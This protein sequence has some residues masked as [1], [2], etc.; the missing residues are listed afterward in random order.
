MVYG[1]ATVRSLHPTQTYELHHRRLRDTNHVDP[2]GDRP[3]TNPTDGAH[4]A[5]D[6]G[7][8]LF[9]HQQRQN[10]RDPSRRPTN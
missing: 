8:A 9:G 5:T 1:C 6:A 3:T 7:D 4:P 10:G 2:T